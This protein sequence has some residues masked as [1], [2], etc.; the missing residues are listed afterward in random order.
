M[1]SWQGPQKL[2][3]T[4]H[5]VCK[6]WLNET[7]RSKWPKERKR[8]WA[9]KDKRMTVSRSRYVRNNH[10]LHSPVFALALQRP[11]WKSELHLVAHRSRIKEITSSNTFFF[12]RTP[13]T[14]SNILQVLSNNV[15]KKK[16]QTKNKTMI[17]MISICIGGVLFTLWVREFGFGSHSDVSQSSWR[18]YTRR[19][20]RLLAF[21]LV[22][23]LLKKKIITY[24]WSWMTWNQ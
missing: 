14:P 5:S 18:Y 23:L 7:W 20:P 11:F 17:F 12:P 15:A 4:S 2:L 8:A 16:T 21:I 19:A 10:G 24:S 9:P 1:A 3:T 6:P 13:N 22:P